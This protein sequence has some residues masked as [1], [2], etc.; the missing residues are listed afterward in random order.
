MSDTLSKSLYVTADKLVFF[1]TLGLF[2]YSLILAFLTDTWLLALLIGGG[3]VVVQGALFRMAAGSL[4]TRLS[5]AA[6]FMLMCALHIQQAKGLIEI[7]FGIFVLL[8]FLLAYQDW[9]PIVVGAAVIAVHHLSFHFMQMQGLPVYVMQDMSMGLAM[10][11]LHA[12]YVVVE[13]AVLVWLAV[14][15]RRQTDQS[16]ALL[17]AI[18]QMTQESSVD[19]RVRAEGD[20]GLVHTYN[21]FLDELTTLMRD[22]GSSA[23]NLTEQS[24]TLAVVTDKIKLSAAEQ[25]HEND[26]ISSS[27]RE[28][29]LAVAEVSQSANNASVSAA[30]VDESARSAAKI[31]NET[32]A[33][34]QQL[35]NQ[36]NTASVT[37]EQLD[38]HTQEITEVLTVIQ[39]ITEQTNLLAL[40]AAIE[41]ARAGEHGRGFAVVADEVR[42]LAQRTQS[43]TE[44]IERMIKQLQHASNSAVSD[45]RNSQSNVELCV[46]NV[47]SSAQLMQE[48]SAAIK[49]V[50]DMNNS[51]AAA[52]TEQSAV[53][54]QL[55]TNLDRLV[56]QAEQV[57]QNSADSAG[58]TEQLRELAAVLKRNTENFKY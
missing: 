25:Q 33:S 41:A 23:T 3:L 39:S 14:Q 36:I 16:N 45:I 13:T 27:I 26:V 21:S 43:S 5:G 2:A 31:S 47:D 8:A 56:Q 50:S 9:R 18:N 54:D 12:L 38:G 1:V 10:V 7:H 37:I 42:E 35:A 34:I 30:E 51:I 44:Q 29:N 28:I 46:S 22:L 48:A 20:T 40:N 55:T 15:M 58:V 32:Q 52:S 6:I 53:L 4:I 11:L 49:T 57:A 19:L 17:S 24:A